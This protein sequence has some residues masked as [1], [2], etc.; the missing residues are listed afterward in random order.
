MINQTFYG[1]LFLMIASVDAGKMTA[2]E[3]QIRQEEKM[4]MLGPV[5]ERLEHELLNPLITRTFN[6]MNRRGMFP[7][8]PD[9]LAGQQIKIEYVSMLAIAQKSS[10]LS[11]LA[12]LLSVAGS[13]AQM[14]P[15]VTDKL[16]ADEIM[17]QYVRLSNIPSAMIRSDGEVA[18]I[19]EARAR[20]Q[21]AA[22]EMMMMQAAAGA[23]RQG[24]G[25]AKDLAAAP[26]Q[27]G[28]VMDAIL[29]SQTGQ[30][31]GM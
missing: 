16:D 28:T 17:D 24:A 31:G 26:V 11:E 15:E 23:A 8:P 25:A 12:N 6:I 20:Q 3:A 27:Q 4:Q 7:P 9:E 19:R 30:E 29:G 5:I 18:A 1:D 14:N 22:Q 21:Q 10:G 13:L 2:T